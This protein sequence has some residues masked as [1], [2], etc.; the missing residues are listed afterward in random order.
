MELDFE[1][2][3]N[4]I[5]EEM[6]QIKNN[7]DDFANINL[8]IA[9]QRE[10]AKEKTKEK[11]TIYISVI[12]KTGNINLGK[13]V[14]PFILNIIS[15][16]NKIKLCEQLI[17][18]F[19]DTF[20]AHFDK[21]N[22]ILQN[23]S[24]PIQIS[25][26]VE[27]GNTFRAT[28]SVD[29]I[30]SIAP[31]LNRITAVYY[32]DTANHQELVPFLVVHDNFT[33]ALN[34]QPYPD[35]QGKTKSYSKYAVY[36]I[37]FTTYFLTTALFDAILDTINNPS[38]AKNEKAYTFTIQYKNG[39]ETTQDFHLASSDKIQKLDTVGSVDISFTN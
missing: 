2:L 16:E 20:N 12:F 28:Y 24:S 6:L 17:N 19:T 33:I 8:S 14:I 7:S 21:T 29:G 34:P 5:R 36:T 32:H 23:Y 13:N 22:G 35:S 11:N 4:I 37:T 10:F 18:K 38:Y 39:E 9:Q 1:S 3:T 30:F 26:F 31:S 27:V 15:E 25:S